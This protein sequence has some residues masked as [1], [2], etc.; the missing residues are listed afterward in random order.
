MVSEGIFSLSYGT[1]SFNA[2][3]LLWSA[4]PEKIFSSDLSKS[5]LK[6]ERLD[7][8]PGSQRLLCKLDVGL[9]ASSEEMRMME[10]KHI[11]SVNL[12]NCC[13]TWSI[14]SSWCFAYAFY[15]PVFGD[16]FCIINKLVLSWGIINLDCVMSANCLWT[17]F[18]SRVAKSK[19]DQW[20]LVLINAA[21]CLIPVVQQ[22]L[23]A[24]TM[25]RSLVI[26]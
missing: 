12:N 8:D 21:Y 20:Y 10:K 4:F 9:W 11:S 5:D 7:K 15:R 22:Q 23:N 18:V 2:R 25:E 13:L 17:G 14:D 6:L 26:N 1:L 24:P 19:C 16:L 3:V